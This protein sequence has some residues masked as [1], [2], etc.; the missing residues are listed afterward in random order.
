M[1]QRLDLPELDPS[2]ELTL[3]SLQAIAPPCAPLSF[4]DLIAA[5]LRE[6]CEADGDAVFPIIARLIDQHIAGA[7]QP[8]RIGRWRDEALDD[9][10]SVISPGMR[11]RAG[12]ATPG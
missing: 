5:S 6:A 11:A 2:L 9:L 1:D 8:R 12:I 7:L 10:L 4:A 3:H